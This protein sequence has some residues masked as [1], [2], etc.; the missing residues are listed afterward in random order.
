M[1]YFKI[2]LS[3]LAL[4]FFSTQISFA[5]KKA[6]KENVSQKESTTPKAFHVK[7]HVMVTL[8]DGSQV[9]A[10]VHGHVSKKKYWVRQ[11]HSGREGNVH[12]KYIRALTE[13]EV[14]ELKNSKKK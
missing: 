10:V 11:W 13:S 8:K 14:S 3:V 9:E 1:K 4:I 5:Q 12:E 6:K 2:I 7:Q